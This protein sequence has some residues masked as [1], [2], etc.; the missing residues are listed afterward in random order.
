V[1]VAVRCV[2]HPDNLLWLS[3]ILLIGTVVVLSTMASWTGTAIFV[4]VVGLVLG[5]SLII[6]KRQGF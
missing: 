4:A 2:S 3:P 5:S 6:G 1:A